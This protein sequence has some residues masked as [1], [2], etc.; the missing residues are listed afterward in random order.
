MYEGDPLPIVDVVMSES[1][2]RD[3]A[4]LNGWQK[5]TIDLLLRLIVT[6]R[7]KRVPLPPIKLGP[8]RITIQ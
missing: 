3:H 8:E 7:G 5:R 1:E 6:P 2:F 4:I